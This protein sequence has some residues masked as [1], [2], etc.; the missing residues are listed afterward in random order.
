MNDCSPTGELLCSQGGSPD[1]LFTVWNWKK[2]K[3]M[4]RTRSSNTDVLNCRFSLYMP[5]HIATGGTY[6]ISQLIGFDSHAGNL[7]CA[8]ALSVADFFM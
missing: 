4:L 3:I 2:E 8:E 5:G 6:A 1:Y 7:L